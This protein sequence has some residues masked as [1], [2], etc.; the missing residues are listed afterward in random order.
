LMWVDLEKVREKNRKDNS[1][2]LI[3]EK[4]WTKMSKE[5]RKLSGKK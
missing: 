4:H 2:K 3:F 5:E 1:G